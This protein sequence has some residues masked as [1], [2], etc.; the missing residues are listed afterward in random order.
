MK[1]LES[2][3]L[4]EGRDLFEKYNDGTDFDGMAVHSSGNIFTSGPGGLLVISP[5]GKLMARIDFSHITNCTFDD[6]E[7]YLYAT[8]FID[9]PK[10]FRIKLNN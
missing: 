3:T 10:I 7:K 8:G 4:F 9:N 2:E 6:E 1:T 5:N